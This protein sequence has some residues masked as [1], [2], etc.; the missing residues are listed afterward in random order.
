MNSYLN[1]ST[2]DLLEELWKFSKQTEKMF[3]KVSLPI[4]IVEFA[5]K[6]G[7]EIVY[8][9]I[10]QTEQQTFGVATP[11]EIHVNKNL[12]YK[13]QRWAIAKAMAYFLNNSNQ[14]EML[15]FVQ[16]PY[17]VSDNVDEFYTDV[18]AILL[19]LP[20]TLF[21]QE[22]SKYIDRDDLLQ[23]LSD[24]SQIPIFQLSI[25]Y[26]FIK[27]MLSFKRQ[28]DFE[29]CHYDVESFTVDEYENIY[30]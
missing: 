11:K 4:D 7:F 26:Q 15:F 10:A 21:K 17:F 6:L 3:E 28:K 16:S 12:K 27:Q 25:G 18:M 30:I 1:K 5:R 24:I 14:K 20:I 29:E 19:L 2:G 13:E 9:E 8:D 23:R 22:V